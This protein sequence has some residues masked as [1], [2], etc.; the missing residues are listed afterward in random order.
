MMNEIRKRPVDTLGY[1]FISA[2]YIPEGNDEYSL[3]NIQNRSGIEYRKLSAYEIEVLVRNRNTSDD[4]NK[5][6]VSDA[7]TPELV[8]NC[9]FYGLV[10]IGKLEPYF[11]EFSDIKYAVGLYNSTIIST[12]IGDN[13][14]VDHVN[15]LSHYILGNEC[16]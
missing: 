5:L 2:E 1:N 6:L 9:K 14:V 10:R 4:W 12:D 8:K 3:R 15:Y 11:L 7:F 16:I 13:V